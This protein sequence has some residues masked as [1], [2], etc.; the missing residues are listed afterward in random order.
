M[1]YS[2]AIFSQ[3]QEALACPYEM[4]F[5]RKRESRVYDFSLLVDVVIPSKQIMTGSRVGFVRLGRTKPTTLID[6]LSHHY[7]ALRLCHH[8]AYDGGVFEALTAHS[9]NQWLGICGGHGD[10]QAA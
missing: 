1:R 8:L 6:E 10:E 3:Q 9:F 2:T 5:P 7:S 4:S